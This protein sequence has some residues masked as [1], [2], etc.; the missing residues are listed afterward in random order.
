MPFVV[1]KL[2]AIVSLRQGR[3]SLSRT[4]PQRS[5]THSPW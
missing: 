4:P 2:A 3:P 5:T 1:E